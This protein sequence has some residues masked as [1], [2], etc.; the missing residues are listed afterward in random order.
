MDGGHKGGCQLKTK[1]LGAE[2]ACTFTVRRFLVDGRPASVI[3][4]QIKTG[5]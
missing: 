2:G 5:D 4:V 1:E 3:F